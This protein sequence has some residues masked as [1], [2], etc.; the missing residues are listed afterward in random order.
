MKTLIA[1][2]GGVDSSVAAHLLLKA[3]QE[4]V[5]VTMRLHGIACGT[6]G[7]RDAAAVAAELGL[8]HS[9]YDFEG[10]FEK[11]V[12]R[13]FAETYLAGGTPN[14]CI[15]CNRRL[16]F[17]A[18]Y[19]KARELGCDKVATGHY[20]RI[21]YSEKYGRRVLMRGRDLSKDQSYVL[22]GLTREQ[23]EHTLFP[24]GE[25]PKEEVRTLA[26]AL[27]LSSAERKDSQ[28][29]CFVPDGDYAA[30]LERFLNQTFEEG[31]FVDGDGNLLGRHRGIVRYTVGQR[32]GLGLSLPAP[33]Y[34]AEKDP[35]SNTVL[36]LPE[37]KL[38]KNEVTVCDTV[39]SAVDAL[40]EGMR[41]EAKIRYSQAAMPARVCD[42]KDTTFRLV[43]DTPVRAPAKGQA[44]VLYDGEIVI[45]GGTIC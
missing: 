33:L 31:D 11:E 7:E 5:G 38:F 25:L 1:M 44:A 27:G 22:Y 8:P 43:F 45:G 18:L 3:G 4:C 39:L 16:K 24:I 13:P 23:I 26:R 15:L 42:V 17:G 30:F 10:D 9:V 41:V 19:E 6:D 35:E 34:V 12:I 2:S 21:A 14:P 32:K 20:A 29:I 28:D 40:Y 37:E 36:L